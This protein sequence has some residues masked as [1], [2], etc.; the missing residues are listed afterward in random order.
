MAFYIS[1]MTNIVLPFRCKETPKAPRSM[2]DDPT[3]T[4]FESGDHATLLA[5]AMLGCLTVPLPSIAMAVWITCQ[6]PVLVVRT[7]SGILL[8]RYR[9]LLGRFAT[10]AYWCGLSWGSK[11]TVL[12]RIPVVL[13][14]EPFL[15]VLS[16]V[17]ILLASFAL[18]CWITPWHARAVNLAGAVAMP[19]DVL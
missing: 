5:L 4:C 19:L 8:T 17:P 18:Q 11:N 12:F 15:E 1:I 6:Y 13:V 14:S 10:A 7:Y 2:A 16:D 3:V 9:C